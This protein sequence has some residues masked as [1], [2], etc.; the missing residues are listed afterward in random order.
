[1]CVYVC[2]CACRVWCGI[3]WCGAVWCCVV[4]CVFCVGCVCVSVCMC[5]CVFCVFCV[6]A[7]L[8]MYVCMLGANETTTKLCYNKN[9]NFRILL[10]SRFPRTKMFLD[11]TPAS[12]H[13]PTPSKANI[14]LFMLQQRLRYANK[15]CTYPRKNQKQ[16]KYRNIASSH[17]K[18]IQTD[19]DIETAINHYIKYVHTYTKF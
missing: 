11:N 2:V 4:F 15:T 19:I 9:C 18:Y 5:V 10:S 6:C 1:M 17:T 8:S 16:S 13:A 7:R 12:C 14:L 3:V